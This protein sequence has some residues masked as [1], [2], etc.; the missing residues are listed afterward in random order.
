MVARVTAVVVL[1]FAPRRVP[2][3]AVMAIVAMD[4][5]ND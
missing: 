2:A 3:F 5:A 1:F 4:G